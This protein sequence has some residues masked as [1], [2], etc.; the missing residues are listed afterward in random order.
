MV[1]RYAPRIETLK[2]SRERELEGVF[3]SP[4][5]KGVWDSFV[6]FPSGVWDGDGRAADKH[7]CAVRASN[8]AFSDRKL[9][10]T[11]T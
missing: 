4:A 6:N 9:F 10:S 1:L 11:R 5:Y 2:A 7:F 8:N 3:P